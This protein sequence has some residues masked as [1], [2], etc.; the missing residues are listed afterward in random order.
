MGELLNVAP[1][2]PAVIFGSKLSF[3]HGSLQITYRSIRFKMLPPVSF[4]ITVNESRL[5]STSREV[6]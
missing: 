5:A 3:I 6:V 1:I 4:L 2:I